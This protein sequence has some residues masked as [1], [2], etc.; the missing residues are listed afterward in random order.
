MKHQVVRQK[1]LKE[2]AVLLAVIVVMG[3]GAFYASL[4]V[5]DYEQQKRT[6][7]NEVNTITNQ[8]NNLREKFNKVN[9][10]KIYEEIEKKNSRNELAIDRQAIK[11]KFDDYRGTYFLDNLSL[12]VD[13][14]QESA[15]GKRANSA[16]MTSNVQVTFD[17][18]NDE[19]VYR[20]ID[21]MENELPGVVRMTLVNIGRQGKL[22]EEELRALAKNGRIALVRGELRFT[23]L[24]IKNI[25]PNASKEGLNAPR[26]P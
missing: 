26:Q 15:S 4:M 23:W 3:G 1:L 24:G 22:T 13:P 11:K 8:M 14:P 2:G 17:A 6:L 20:L 10:A 21:A 16:I 19:H 5:E 12:T 25:D 7:E 9:N 18:V